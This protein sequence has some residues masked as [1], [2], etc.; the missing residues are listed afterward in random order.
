MAGPPWGRPGMLH[1]SAGVLRK[2]AGPAWAGSGGRSWSWGGGP[3]SPRRPLPVLLV[4]GGLSRLPAPPCGPTPLRPLAGCPGSVTGVAQGRCL[5]LW[6]TSSLT[7]HGPGGTCGGPGHPMA[8]GQGGQ[9]PLGGLSQPCPPA[10]PRAAIRAVAAHPPLPQ[11][12]LLQ[13]TGGHCSG[14]RPGQQSAFCGWC[15][16]MPLV[17][18]GG[19]GGD[20]RTGR[21]A[22]GPRMEVRLENPGAWQGGIEPTPLWAGNL[23]HPGF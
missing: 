13:D 4:N 7:C 3:G 5:C 21:G 8:G 17:A 15:L 1:K 22:G 18:W 6:D 9:A 20:G 10:S 2:L 16:G 12:S 14:G 11:G 23:G 19:W